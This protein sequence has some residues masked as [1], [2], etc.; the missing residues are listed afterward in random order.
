VEKGGELRV[1]YKKTT[2]SEHLVLDAI[3]SINNLWSYCELT[4]ARMS[5]SDKDSS[6]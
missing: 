4:D 2:S 5:A 6:Y 1:Q 3:H